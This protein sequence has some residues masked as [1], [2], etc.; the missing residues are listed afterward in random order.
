MDSRSPLSARSRGLLLIFC[1]AVML[2]GLPVAVWLDLR[3]I[4]ENA[5][6]LQ[7]NDLNITSA[8]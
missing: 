5:L 6:R 3:D 7:A 2:A 8:P 4:S 1:V